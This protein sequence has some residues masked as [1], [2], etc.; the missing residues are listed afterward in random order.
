[1]DREEASWEFLKW[2]MDTE[3]QVEFGSTL[4]TTYGKEFIWNSAN[5][6]ALAQLPW[7]SDAKEVILQQMDWI[8]EAPRIPGTYMLERELSNAYVAVA[9]SGE[10]LRTSID[11]AVKNINRETQRKLEE[12]GYIDSKGN[13]VKPYDVPTID[14]VKKILG[15]E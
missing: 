12:F 2:W 14:T 8:V 7:K 15:Q 13:I 10:N 9:N 6:E 11:A 5:K 4:Q 3:T 1:M